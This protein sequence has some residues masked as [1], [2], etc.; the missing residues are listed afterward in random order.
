[1]SWPSSLPLIPC[2]SPQPCF[3]A[4]REQIFPH[5]SLIFNVNVSAATTPP[6]MDARRAGI[7]SHG[8]RTMQRAGFRGE[9]HLVFKFDSLTHKSS[10]KIWN[11]HPKRKEIGPLFPHDFSFCG[12]TFPHSASFG[13]IFANRKPPFSD[14]LG[15]F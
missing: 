8:H 12:K 13:I 2:P 11:S 4:V 14:R 3:P 15:R 7:S 1:M 10:A 5:F 9:L 6:K